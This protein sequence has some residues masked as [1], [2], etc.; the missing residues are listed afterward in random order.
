MTKLVTWN[1]KPITRYTVVRTEDGPDGGSVE[2]RGEYLSAESAQKVSE[3]YQRE[4][5][6]AAS[7]GA[8]MPGQGRDITSTSQKEK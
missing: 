6:E 5:I 1:I 2:Y 8:R 3:M 7:M 4:E